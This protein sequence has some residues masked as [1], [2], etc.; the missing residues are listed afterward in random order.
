MGSVH[1]GAQSIPQSLHSRDGKLVVSGKHCWSISVHSGMARV[2][3]S[4]HEA[5]CGTIR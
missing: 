2:E 3:R 1:S 4:A 5:E